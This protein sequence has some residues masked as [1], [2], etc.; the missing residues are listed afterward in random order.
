MAT[1]IS[2]QPEKRESGF[3]RAGEIGA[4][5]GTLEA[6][7]QAH[8]RELASR[9]ADLLE[10]PIVILTE[11]RDGALR[12]LEEF[13]QSVEAER[14]E[15]V[16]EQD[17]FINLLMSDQ[18]EKIGELRRQLEAA[19]AARER[20]SAQPA[21]ATEPSEP[22]IAREA[23]GE[24]EALR[25]ALDSATAE[26]EETRK[27]AV[28][29]QEERD[30]AIRTIDDTRIELLGELEA[31]RDEG[32]QLETRLDEAH[33]LLEDAR[34]QAQDEAFRFN[35][36]LSEL[37]RLLDERNDEV[38]RLRARLASH[39]TEKPSVAPLPSASDELGKAREEARQ[40][41]QQLVA[42]KRELARPT[43]AR[44]EHKS[45]RPASTRPSVA[46]AGSSANA[47][48]MQHFDPAV[49]PNRRVTP[50]GFVDPSTKRS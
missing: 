17:S 5:G 1:P 39:V 27:D 6:T 12:L 49:A 21:L 23:S 38:R 42:A 20:R 22:V 14:L 15:L 43:P 4:N 45:A 41:R 31:A 7:I 50:I 32:F 13:R 19:R 10:L 44:P 18:E 24:L 46:P 16:A 30:D 33:R 47:P 2:K 9:A 40:L 29:L 26:I 34:D 36:E 3:Q 11:Q 37:K 28:R 8:N 35:E 25:Q 48:K